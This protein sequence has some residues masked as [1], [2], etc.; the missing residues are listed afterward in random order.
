ME[1]KD[2]GENFTHSMAIGAQKHMSF[3]GTFMQP[4]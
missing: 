1:K 3:L 2:K 4:L